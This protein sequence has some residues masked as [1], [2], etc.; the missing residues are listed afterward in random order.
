MVPHRRR[1]TIKLTIA[2]ALLVA[3]MPL[4]LAAVCSPADPGYGALPSPWLDLDIN[5]SGGC[6][7]YNGTAFKV[8]SLGV[9]VP[10][11]T[12]DSLHYAYRT[13]TGDFTL[14]ARVT[15]FDP[16]STENAHMG[17]MVR[18][19]TASNSRHATLMYTV[20]PGFGGFV[21][22]RWRALTGERILEGGYLAAGIPHY[23]K[24]I[25]YK[26][27][28]VFYESADGTTWTWVDGT[29]LTGLPSTVN[30]GLAVWSS[31]GSSLITGTFDVVSVGAYTPPYTTSWLGNSLPGGGPPV[32]QDVSAIYVD[33]GTGKII[34]NTYWDE[35]GRESTIFTSTGSVERALDDTHGTRLGGHAVTS[36]GSYIYLGI[37]Q[38][39]FEPTYVCGPGNQVDGCAACQYKDF[40]DPDPN[41]PCLP[42]PAPATGYP[43]CGYHDFSVRRYN[44]NGTPAGWTGGGGPDGSML[45]VQ[46][47][48][49]ATK[50]AHPRGLAYNR[51]SKELYVSDTAAGTV[52]I[53]D[54]D[55]HQSGG[56]VMTLLRSFASARCRGSA[57][58]ASGYLWVIQAKATGAAAAIQRY[59]VSAGT[60]FGTISKTIGGGD[61]LDDPT[62]VA[63]SPVDGKIWVADDGPSYQQV[64]IFSQISTNLTGTLGATGGIYSTA[65]GSKKGEARPTKFNGPIGVG[66][67]NSGNVY[68]AGDALEMTGTELR[69]FDSTAQHNPVW[70]KFGLE[71]VDTADADPS[72]DGADLFTRQ[73]HYTMNYAAQPGS[74]WAYK[75]LT[76]DRFGP[77]D[78]NGK[79]HD[80]RLNEDDAGGW[81]GAIIRRFGSTRVMY[82]T[83]H[84]GQYLGIYRF[85]PNSEIAL[86]CG[87]MNSGHR[88][89]AWP[90]NQ[91]STGKWIW[92]DTNGNGLMEA[93]EYVSNGADAFAI[94][95]WNV[96]DAGDI[97][98]AN[99]VPDPST[100][101]PIKRYKYKGLDS[102]GCPIYN[103]SDGSS[104][105][106]TNCEEFKKPA[107]FGTT[108]CDPALPCPTGVTR[109][110]YVPTT[111]TMYVGGFTTSR[112]RDPAEEGDSRI[113]TEIIRYNNWHTCASSTQNTCTP[114]WRV[115]DLPYADFYHAF[116]YLKT[117]KTM[118]VVGD[119]LFV[120]IQ[121]LPA[122]RVYDVCN[123]GNFLTQLT[124]GPEVAGKGSW[125]ISPAG[126]NAIQRSNGE[127]RIFTEEFLG[128]KDLMYKLNPPV[129]GQ[130]L[131]SYC[132][133]AGI[134]CEA[135]GTCGV[136]NCCNYTCGVSMPL[137]T[138]PDTPPENR[139]H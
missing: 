49:D 101:L 62:A 64:R 6:A 70:E 26:D 82:L 100:L 42:C 3:G 138:G 13:F 18:E 71:F 136:C 45:V 52:K 131:I 8:K 10:L 2:L 94:N 80:G 31:N 113:G 119:R 25:R 102:F 55:G 118:D 68:V 12:T 103:P 54:G 84:Y 69:K 47:V 116:D 110:V 134:G 50:D 98:T 125:I 66:L 27:Q 114:A 23:Q 112:P 97:W 86:Q 36:D 132:T 72:S 32:P 40:N 4:C 91:P 88:A 57:V 28:I 92:R 9:F 133:G 38:Q 83:T 76:F 59:Q 46:H 79:R 96:D 41:R 78:A 7:E 21:K 104:C 130:C 115:N 77:A 75:G 22:A 56:N 90:Y 30:V 15:G 24:L 61:R 14:V 89:T 35:G 107:E 48:P 51:T 135:T 74:E 17:L 105:S 1:L 43:A 129:C 29:T 93:G 109:A 53:Y 33:P 85:D 44:L 126:M 67:D 87:M 124:P 127:Y 63:V 111:D 128:A 19:S 99:L 39:Y 120:G 137:C 95:A 121:H 122:V 16:P 5:A 37:E 81:A 65:G 20:P 139:C 34:T 60:G 106:G 58:D 117:T 123:S 108:A 73:T 11:A